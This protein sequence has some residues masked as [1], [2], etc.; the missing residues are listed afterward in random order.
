MVG[1]LLAARLGYRFLDT[2]VMY[3]AMAWY[4]A[5]QGVD[6][7]DEAT[8]ERLALAAT[9]RMAEDD[10]TVFVNGRKAPLEERRREIDKTVSLVARVDGV[11]K[12]MVK[13][14]R[15]IAATGGIVLAGRD[16]GTVVAPDAP[17]KLYL[18]ASAKERALRRC[19]EL[20]AQGL[21]VEFQSILTQLE[22]RDKMDTE[23][24][25]SPL[26]PADDA[27]IITT[28]GITIEQVLKKA[29]ELADG[30]Q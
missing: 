17:L 29:L 24:E 5:E 25:H 11:R 26:R 28:E 16:I 12:A 21:K 27:H 6:P 4:A 10:G 14:Q 19:K 1:R 22:G 20:E 9:M 8:L 13:Q 15:Q 7:L 2:G 18:D 23:R 3:R 30:D